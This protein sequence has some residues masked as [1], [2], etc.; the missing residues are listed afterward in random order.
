MLC[1]SKES[2][3]PHYLLTKYQIKDENQNKYSLP[4]IIYSTSPPS[5]MKSS[6]VNSLGTGS[7]NNSASRI[8]SKFQH[9]RATTSFSFLAPPQILS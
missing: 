1:L 4:S 6:M 8:L 5:A 3:S 7:F 9:F 2:A